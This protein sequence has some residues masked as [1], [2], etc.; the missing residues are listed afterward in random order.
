MLFR[1][2]HTVTAT[3]ERHESHPLRSREAWTFDNSGSESCSEKPL[4]ASS[5][6]PAVATWT[7]LIKI[8]HRLQL[9]CAVTCVDKYAQPA[10]KQMRPQTRLVPKLYDSNAPW[11]NA[12]IPKPCAPYSAMYLISSLAL[13]LLVTA[14]PRHLC[15]LCHE[16]LPQRV[17]ILTE[18]WQDHAKRLRQSLPAWTSP[19]ASLPI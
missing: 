17:S 6:H 1:D 19:S 9:Y 15:L 14:S 4:E 10:S 5:M 12:C 11:Q 2:R 3:K 18:Q 7:T 13:L 16:L 8:V